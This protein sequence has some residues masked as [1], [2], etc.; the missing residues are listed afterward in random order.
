[1]IY[2]V[3]VTGSLDKAVAEMPFLWLVREDFPLLLTLTFSGGRTALTARSGEG[4]ITPLNP[5][6]TPW[7]S[8]CGNLLD[9]EILGLKVIYN[10]LPEQ[11]LKTF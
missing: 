2:D 5:R 9:N 7:I 3:I 11:N 8:Y 10:I 4:R 6:F 1:M